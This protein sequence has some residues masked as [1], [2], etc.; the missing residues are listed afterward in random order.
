MKCKLWGEAVWLEDYC[1]GEAVWL[2]DYC[3]GEEVWLE[4]YCGGEAVWLED[5]CRV[6]AVWLEDYCRIGGE[7]RFGWRITVESGEAVWF[8][9]FLIVLIS[10][11]SSYHPRSCPVLI[12]KVR[13]GKSMKNCVDINFWWKKKLE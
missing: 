13:R 2:E 3:R 10:N 9:E 5:Y 7:K 6:E 4:D 8:K 1:R 12:W 11:S